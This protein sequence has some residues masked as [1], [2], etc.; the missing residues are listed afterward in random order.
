[1]TERE[2]PMPRSRSYHE[3]LPVSAQTPANYR[4]STPP[5][6]SPVRILAATAAPTDKI[7]IQNGLLRRP[8]CPT[9]MVQRRAIWAP[10][11]MAVP[12]G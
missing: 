10:A 4:D 12:D 5:A 11:S 7:L 3:A 1:M 6:P 2:L 8:L 9:S